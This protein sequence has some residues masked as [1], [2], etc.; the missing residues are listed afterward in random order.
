MDISCMILEQVY[1][2]AALYVKANLIDE[3]RNIYE[4]AYHFSDA[5]DL[6]IKYGRYDEAIDTVTRY[7]QLV[8]VSFQF[9]LF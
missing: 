3:A 9:Y 7:Q 8:D 6:L 2:A 1:H 4:T 5:V